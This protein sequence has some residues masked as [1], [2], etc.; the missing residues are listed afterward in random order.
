MCV[1]D[2]EQC[3]ALPV[4]EASVEIADSGGRVLATGKTDDI[5][6][7]TISAPR[8]LLG[9]KVTVRSP[10]FRGG[11]VEAPLEQVDEGGTSVTVRGELASGVTGS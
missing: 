3:Y 10:L 11:F 1:K 7:V 5:G 2:A 9:G 8:S 6:R 4:P